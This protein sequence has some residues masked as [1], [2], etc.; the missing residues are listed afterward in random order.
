MTSRG[1]IDSWCWCWYMTNLN[2]W[3]FFLCDTCHTFFN[4]SI[5]STGPVACVVWWIRCWCC[6]GQSHQSVSASSP[7][8]RTA[9]SGGSLGGQVRTKIHF[10]L[11][12][13]PF[14][15]QLWEDCEKFSYTDFS[16][17]QLIKEIFACQW[18][19]VLVL[20]KPI[21]LQL[22]TLDWF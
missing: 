7:V 15:V 19:L 2:C 11:H 6:P 1:E 16:L 14:L 5:S 18:P 10:F 20:D 22:I 12:F 3:S 4:P 17:A 9:S 13:S 21:M 8:C